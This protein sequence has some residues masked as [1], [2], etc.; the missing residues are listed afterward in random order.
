M[1]ICT[2]KA[3]N[4]KFFAAIISAVALLVALVAITGGNASDA[5]AASAAPQV[6]KISFENVRTN[7]DRVSFLGQFGWEVES[8]PTEEV[9]LRLPAE[10]DSIMNEYNEIQRSQGLDL[11]KYTGNE[12]TRYS[13]KVTNYPGYDG[14]VRANVITA[15]SRVVAG[16]VCSADPDGF[17][18]SLYRPDTENKTDEEESEEAA[19]SA[20]ISPE[21]CEN[22]ENDETQNASEAM[23]EFDSGLPADAGAP[24]DGTPEIADAAF[25]AESD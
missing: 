2:L 19:A 18:G 11:S 4:I 20:V 10:F 23:N 6:R 8:E 3:S 21:T 14:E 15:K 16:D 7:D 22:A 1:F 5:L 25:S 24:W 12:V 17:I 9:T 13:Y